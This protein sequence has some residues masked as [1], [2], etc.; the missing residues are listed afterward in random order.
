MVAVICVK[1]VKKVV[2]GFV[3]QVQMRRMRLLIGVVARSHHRP[4]GRV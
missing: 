3:G 2:S 1:G 4:H